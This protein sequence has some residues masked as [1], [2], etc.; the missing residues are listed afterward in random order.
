MKRGRDGG[1]ADDDTVGPSPLF[2]WNG[3]VTRLRRIDVQKPE[4]PPG[5]TAGARP[6]DGGESIRSPPWTRSRA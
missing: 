2:I 5:A 4:T 1:R 3:A 6:G